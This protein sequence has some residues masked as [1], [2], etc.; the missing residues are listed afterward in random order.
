VPDELELA[1]SPEVLVG[2]RVWRVARPIDREATALELAAALLAAE[3]RGDFGSVEDLFRLRLRSLT[4]PTFWPVGSRLEASCHAAAQEHEAP[5]VGCECGIWAFRSSAAVEAT[6]AAYRYCGTPIAFGRV[7]LWGRVIEH[8]RGW[9]GA[10][11]APLDLFVCGSSA[12]A[13]SEVAAA[14]GVEASAVP[15]PQVDPEPLVERGPGQVA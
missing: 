5:C 3:R 9:R 4:E 7:A 10:L 8:E 11:A 13:T 1:F 14:Y 6:V 12:A 2:W 15:W